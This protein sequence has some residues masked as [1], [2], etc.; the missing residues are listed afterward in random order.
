MFTETE[1]A[2]YRDE[3]RKHVCTRCFFQRPLGGPPCAPFGKQCVVE[4][5]LPEL[6]AAIH[7]MDSSSVIPFL[8]NNQHRICEHCPEHYSSDC[9]CPL[10]YF[11]VLIVQA[12]ET[13]DERRGQRAVV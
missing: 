10:D 8:D 1:L 2:E 12:V 4:A 13:V 5:L 3:I 7:E 11:A 6:I 9:R